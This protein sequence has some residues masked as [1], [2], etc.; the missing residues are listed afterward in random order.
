MQLQRRKNEESKEAIEKNKKSKIEEI[1]EWQ[2]GL[3]HHTRQEKENYRHQVALQRQSQRR[4][5]QEKR[6][7]VAL[8][9]ILSHEKALLKCQ[10]KVESLH[11]K[12]REDTAMLLQRQSEKRR[13]I[14][15]M[16]KLEMKIMEKY[17]V[18]QTAYQESRRKLEG[19]LGVIRRHRG[20]KTT[21]NSTSNYNSTLTTYQ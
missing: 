1:M 5:N 9:S 18:S 7:R 8:S 3:A 17:S 6:S 11:E 2:L 12:K 10:S 16:S 19:M 21:S 13:E 14:E 20:D 4:H 15:D